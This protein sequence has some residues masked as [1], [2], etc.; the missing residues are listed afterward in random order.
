VAKVTESIA[1]ASGDRV[2]DVAGLV[3]A[4]RLI[5]IHVHLHDEATRPVFEAVACA[6]TTLAAS[7]GATR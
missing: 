3:V 6:T 2:V 5:A 7:P 4:P 1:P